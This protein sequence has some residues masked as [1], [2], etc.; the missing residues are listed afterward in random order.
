MMNRPC[1]KSSVLVTHFGICVKGTIGI[2]AARC[3]G[4]NGVTIC[5]ESSQNR[6]GTPYDDHH[7]T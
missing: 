6:E 2:S 4:V 5:L 3:Q 1:F 7:Q